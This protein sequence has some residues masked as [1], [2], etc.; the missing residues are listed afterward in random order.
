MWD[1]G[2]IKLYIDNLLYFT[3]DVSGSNSPFARNFFFIFNIAVGGDW[4]GAPDGT[5][6]FPQRMVVDYI[7]VFQ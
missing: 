6:P 3:H 7:R 2:S 1:V 4:P 5:T